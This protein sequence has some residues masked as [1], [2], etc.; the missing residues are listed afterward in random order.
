M[1]QQTMTRVSTTTGGKDGVQK[2]AGGEPVNPWFSRVGCVPIV[3]ALAEV[4]REEIMCY[5]F[6]IF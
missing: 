2:G 4:C 1:G 6:H 5:P 3:Q